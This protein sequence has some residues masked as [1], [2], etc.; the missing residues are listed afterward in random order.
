MSEAKRTLL[1]ENSPHDVELIMAALEECKIFTEVD[2][3]YDG[4]QALDYL[5]RQK[6]FAERK[7]DP[8]V[9]LLD[10]K[11][12]KLDG[13][14]VLQRI[15]TNASLKI[16]PVV[17]LTSSAEEQDLVSSYC[18]GVNAYVVKPVDFHKFVEVIKQIGIFW[19]ETN[20]LPHRGEV[21]LC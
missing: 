13:L 2:V 14:E 19:G 16:L 5:F 12:P 18:L 3:V 7:G 8:M 4:E 1:V 9:V 15:K 20:Q 11:L 17:M 6:D 21:D 10:L